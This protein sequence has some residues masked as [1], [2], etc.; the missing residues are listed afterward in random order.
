M[1]FPNADHQETRRLTHRFYRNLADVFIE[2]L[3]LLHVGDA[4][5]HRRV[6]V[7]NADLINNIVLSGKSVV[8]YLGHY[9]NW[10]W[11]TKIVMHFVP[12][13]QSG[14]IYHPLTSKPFDMLML[15]I[16]SRFNGE[17]IPMHS[18]FRHLAGVQR[19][20][21]KFITGFI[22]DQRPDG[23]TIHKTKFLGIDTPVIVG[24][25]VLG[26]RLDT[27]F[28]YADV[29]KVSR[30]HYRVTFKPVE[31]PPGVEFSPEADSYPVTDAYFRMLES[32]I[33][34]DPALWLWSHN[35]WK[36]QSPS[37]INC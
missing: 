18:A 4:E 6:E 20:G 1:V 12:E 3:K 26:N 9:A 2:S 32:T 28:A 11:V 14:Q 35:R 25:E 22:S 13:A 24:G 34:R 8:L 15:K 16:R 5:M 33:L 23:K 17:N 36:I 7:V 27:A 37:H 29:E 31:I 30:G 10:E 19:A 21:R